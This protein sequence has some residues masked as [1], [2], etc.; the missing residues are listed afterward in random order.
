[1][2]N[3]KNS[4]FKWVKNH[5]EELIFGGICIAVICG[6]IIVINNPNTL[7]FAWRHFNNSVET[8]PKAIIKPLPSPVIAPTADTLNASI[9]TTNRTPHT[10]SRHIRNLPIGWNA[11]EEKIATAAKHGY[12]LMPGQTWVEQYETGYYTA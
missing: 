8:K 11:S 1:M 5:K 2:E 9:Q 6:T 3:K 12:I 10:V 4:F 7:T